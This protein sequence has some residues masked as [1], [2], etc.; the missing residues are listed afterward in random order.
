MITIPIGIQEPEKGG[1]VAMAVDLNK[2]AERIRQK[3]NVSAT[4]DGRI[5]ERDPRDNG[6]SGGGNTNASPF[7]R[8][9]AV[10]V[11]V[12]LVTIVTVAIGPLLL[13][14]FLGLVLLGAGICGYGAFLWSL[15]SDTYDRLA[16]LPQTNSKTKERTGNSAKSKA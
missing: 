5:V 16:N 10:I 11:C 9:V 13:Q 12:C 15:S 6:S 2:V 7:T 8:T 1:V 3:Q 14:L 4:R